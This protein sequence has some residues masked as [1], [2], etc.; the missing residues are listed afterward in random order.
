MFTQLLQGYQLSHQKSLG[1]QTVVWTDV[2]AGRSP[3]QVITWSQPAGCW[4][5]LPGYVIPLQLCISWRSPGEQPPVE[6][7]TKVSTCSLAAISLPQ[8]G[9]TPSQSPYRQLCGLS[10]PWPFWHLSHTAT[11]LVTVLSYS[12]NGSFSTGTH[13]AQSAWAVFL[14]TFSW[15]PS[16]THWMVLAS[17]LPYLYRRFGSANQASQN[18]PLLEQISTGDN[19]LSIC[20]PRNDLTPHTV[21]LTAAHE[22]LIVSHVSHHFHCFRLPNSPRTTEQLVTSPEIQQSV[23]WE[24][25]KI[26]ITPLQEN[27]LFPCM[28]SPPFSVLVPSPDFP[29]HFWFSP[30]PIT[31][32][33]GDW[34][35]Q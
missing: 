28:T 9:H 16:W 17:L 13:R 26:L 4:L 31:E 20:C 23:Q 27:C 2:F 33:L 12:L 10:L 32:Q 22:W 25:A 3:A 34:S 11:V 21:L 6:E 30:A 19:S 29:A 15:L 24:V 7:A 8:S 5:P 18:R 1:Q 14:T 35:H